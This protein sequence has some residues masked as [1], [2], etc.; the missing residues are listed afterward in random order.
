MRVLIAFYSKTGRTE[1]VAEEM[2]KALS[3]A[4]HKAVLSKIVP[5]HKMRAAKY[6][7]S[8]KVALDN[9]PLKLREFDLVFVGTPVWN[10]CPSPIVSSYLRQLKNQ[11]GKRFALFSTCTGLPGTTNKRMAN[12]L[13]MEKAS[14]LGSI[15]INS[16]F[17][18]DEALLARA[19]EFAVNAANSVKAP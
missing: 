18:L 14:V 12:I 2:A 5:L 13:A 8:G 15:T 11:P 6:S 19:R 3:K 17:D 7:K 4:R 16:I 10:F 9:P 1:K